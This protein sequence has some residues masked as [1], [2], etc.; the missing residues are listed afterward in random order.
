MADFFV[1]NWRAAFVILGIFSFG[2]AAGGAAL[3]IAVVSPVMRRNREL[4][5][6]NDKL[7]RAL[8][9]RD[10]HTRDTWP[11]EGVKA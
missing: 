5:E 10:P 7:A 6:E 11:S 8:R 3:W 1:Q 2:G 4:N 9:Q